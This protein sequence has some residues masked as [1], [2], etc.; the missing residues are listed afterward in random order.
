MGKKQYVR[1]FYEKEEY[2]R[3]HDM[4]SEL[5]IG[6]KLEL[7]KVCC[8]MDYVLTWSAYSR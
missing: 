7:I 2:E 1:S 6:N 4:I 8:L 5:D 3:Y